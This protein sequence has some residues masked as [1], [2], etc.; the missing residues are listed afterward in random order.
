MTRI[1]S[2]VR[3]TF[4]DL[5][6]CGDLEDDDSEAKPRRKGLY[7]LTEPHAHIHGFLAI[8]INGRCLPHLDFFPGDVCVGEWAFQLRAALRVLR[9]AAS[10]RFVFDEGEQG[11]PA[12]VFERAGDLLLVSVAASDLGG[13]RAEPDW[14][15]VACPFVDFE[16]GVEEFLATFRAHLVHE[17]HA[18]GE[19]WWQTNV[20]RDS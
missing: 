20:E 9:I 3:L 17:A 8:E 10:S 1:D 5:W 4:D 19:A 6:V 15:Q 11:Q 7:E 14:Q 13:G 2:I 18:V 16:E 12:F